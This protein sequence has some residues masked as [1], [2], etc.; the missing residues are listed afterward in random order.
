MQITGQTIN[1]NGRN[2]RITWAA[3]PGHDGL[4]T[5]FGENNR[6]TELQ[7]FLRVDTTGTI[8]RHATLAGA[9]QNA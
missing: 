2:Y 9:W 4:T 3:E 5:A 8:T 1:R 7:F 6:G